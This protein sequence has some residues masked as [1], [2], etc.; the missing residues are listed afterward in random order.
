MNTTTVF[1]KNLE[2][3]LSRDKKA[4]LIV[5]QGGSS[6][7]KTY[8]ILQLLYIIARYSM[9]PL[10]IH[11]VSRSLPH[12]KMGA[13][14]D[15]ENI[16]IG[17]GYS[18]DSV[19]NKT[20]N[21]FK[22]GRSTLMFY[23]VEDSA[24]VHGPRRDILYINECNHIDYE[25][26]RQLAIRTNQTIFLDYNPTRSF[27][28]HEKILGIIETKPH[29]YIQSTYKDNEE[30][31]QVIVD[32]L[33]SNKTDENWWN[34]YGLGNTGRLEGAILKNWDF[35]PFDYSMPNAFGLDFG[36]KDPDAMV[37]AAIDH[38]RK[39]IYL[40]EEIYRTG[41]NTEQLSKLIKAVPGG[42]NKL[43]IADSAGKRNIDD[44]RDI[45]MLNIRAV[46]KNPIVDD[47]KLLWNY[48]LIIDPTSKNLEK[49]LSSWE[50]LDKRGEV[51]MDA[52]NHLIDA[53]RYI[54]QTMLKP[55]R[56]AASSNRYGSKSSRISTYSTRR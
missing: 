45:Y 26:Y 27:W 29:T 54:T 38:A 13:M 49:E 6:S 32:E 12:L 42:A 39:Q 22:I 11:I 37:R 8:S 48:K 31:S 43:I 28:V 30:L 33:E 47:I 25:V 4:R 15:F 2:A 1:S 50:W 9:L 41:N 5:N 24:K 35:G 40:K 34:V 20:D 52:F 53:T 46:K 7:S 10:K 51:P 21:Y 18:I 36:T 16:L 23:G 14:S 17:E 19:K 56:G 3:Y 55:G 44:L